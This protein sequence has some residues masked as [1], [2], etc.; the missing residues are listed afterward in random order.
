MS[1]TELMLRPEKVGVLARIRDT[2]RSYTIGPLTTKSPEL[3][4]YFGGGPTLSGIH[5]SEDS[6][7]TFSAVWSAV[8]MISDDIASLPLNLYKRLPGGGKE[9]FDSHPLYKLLRDAPNPE[10]DSMVFRR[11][12]QTHLLLWQ[13]AYA[14]IERDGIG[15]P[16]ALWP[17][18]PESVRLYRDRSRAL[19][20][21]V[22]NPSGTETD[23][24]PDDMLHLVGHSHDGS[25]GCSLVQN[26]RES[27]ALG[28]AAERFGGSFFGNG[29]TFGGVLSFPGPKPS[30]L[31]DKNFREMLNA[32]HQG[33]ER[34]HKLLALYNGATY[35]RMGVPPNDAQFLETRVFQI[36]EVAR[37]FKIPPHK[38]ADLA[39]ATFSNVEHQNLD[40]FGS[41]LRPWLAL[42]EQQ[43]TRKL[44]ARLELTQ[45]LIEHETHAFLAADAAGRA[46]LYTA[47]SNIGSIKINEIRGY[48]N[49]NPIDG[50]DDAFIQIQNI[51]VS[52]A[53]Q[54]WELQLQEKQAQIDLLKQ[55]PPAPTTDPQAQQQLQQ[56]STEIGTLRAQVDQ[57]KGQIEDA[58]AD[59]AHARELFD[60]AQ[61]TLNDERSIHEHEKTD[62]ER[63]IAESIK[64]AD[65]N[66]A[67][68]VAVEAHADKLNAL[69]NAEVD[70]HEQTKGTVADRDVALRTANEQTSSVI[71]ERDAVTA[72]LTDVERLRDEEHRDHD[73]KVLTLTTER[74]RVNVE[75]AELEVLSKD[76]LRLLHETG[77]ELEALKVQHGEVT[78]RADAADATN[79][80]I[81]VAK[82]SADAERDAAI[83]ERKAAV[84][85]EQEALALKLAADQRAEQAEKD[86]AIAEQ[87][88]QAANTAA[89]HIRSEW[90]AAR[91]AHATRLAGIAIAQRGLVVDV[92]RRMQEREIDRAKRHQT[93]PE[94]FRAWLDTFYQTHVDALTDALLPAVR[95]HLSLVS[96]NNDP[97]PLARQLAEDHC[98][99][100]ERTLRALLHVDDFAPMLER[101]LRQWEAARPEQ[102]ADR[103]LTRGVEHA[104]N[105]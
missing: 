57:A 28:L 59:E 54:Y 101:T 2:I 10:M 37:W 63:R 94:K 46:A 11:T 61:N 67:A 105:V 91:Q 60:G 99:E 82:Q 47:E 78:R 1:R 16:V 48:E 12:M 43:L 85:A 81:L 33:V 92:M 77:R 100:S 64:L 96:P 50:G 13:N 27:L 40:Y 38:L 65:D 83:H 90:D 19:Q 52:L 74:D 58:R 86:K 102:V 103:V 36:R 75:L 69:F 6:A 3:A 8:T 71:A 70:A 34:A 95:A 88:Q 104:R 42:W 31:D 44:V 80:E 26:A 62:L 24:S 68:R 45:Q 89:E 66:A 41:C 22:R 7:L 98:A 51:P 25:V 20:Y 5:I 29:A 15:R 23:I 21:R 76:T 79:A 18:V 93:T 97:Q 87:A 35:A 84:T 73:A 32:R 9:R 39:D 17:L 56:M 55:P 72:K 49:R 14:E 30:D 4:K 53:R